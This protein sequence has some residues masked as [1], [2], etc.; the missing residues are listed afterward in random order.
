M[1][2]K[3]AQ[4]GGDMTRQQETAPDAANTGSSASGRLPADERRGQIV[5]VAMRLFSERGFRGT[6]TKEIAQAA[7]VSEAIIF[8]HFATK[9]DLYTAIIDYKSCTG[10]GA[11]LG[12]EGEGGGPH[13]MADHLR[14]VISEAM[15]RGD[16]R[17]VFEGLALAMMK[18]HD[19]DPQF[20]RLLL[21]SALEGH[22]LAQIFWDR[23]VRVMYELLGAYIR[24]RQKEGG[25]RDADPFVVVRALTGSVIHHSLNNTL[26][27]KDP[28]RRIL[29]ISNEE[30]ARA[31]ADIVLYGAAA[32]GGRAGRPKA[33]AARRAISKGRKK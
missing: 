6:T 4:P 28:S 27:D 1:S 11:G 5:A 9:E 18:H 13:S 16:D 26:W 3:Q 33:G 14:C 10:V 8:R 21:Y 20:L 12:Q 31:F 2:V 17:A 22:Q 7:G 23:N 19:D 25:L 29:N 32:K 15:E 24:R 30:A